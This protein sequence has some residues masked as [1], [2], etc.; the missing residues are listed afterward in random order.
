MS[1]PSPNVLHE[2]LFQNPNSF[3]DVLDETERLLKQSEE[4]INETILTDYFF[5]FLEYRAFQDFTF[6]AIFRILDE[7]K[8]S[9]K[10]RWN[11]LNFLREH[12]E[13]IY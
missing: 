8:L 12:G 9:E 7:T 5:V 3:F 10:V 13:K 6:E 1:I 2:K 4:N 11:T